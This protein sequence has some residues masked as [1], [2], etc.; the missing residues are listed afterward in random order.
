[1]LLPNASFS[2]TETPGENC[3]K[4]A[5]SP[6][7]LDYEAYYWPSFSPESS[8]SRRQGTRPSFPRLSPLRTLVQTTCSSVCQRSQHAV[9]TVL[10]FLVTIF[11]FILSSHLLSAALGKKCFLLTELPLSSFIRSTLVSWEGQTDHCVIYL[12]W[13]ILFLWNI[14]NHSLCFLPEGKVID[15][16]VCKWTSKS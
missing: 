15:F 12:T 4:D 1:M 6:W 2:A 11:M 16:G 3:V 5:D 10:V 9:L 14:Q 13:Q 7:L 8:N